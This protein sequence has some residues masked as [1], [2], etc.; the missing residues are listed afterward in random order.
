MNKLILPTKNYLSL[1]CLLFVILAASACSNENCIENDRDSK[2]MAEQKAVLEELNGFTTYY[3]NGVYQFYNSQSDY[4]NLDSLDLYILQYQFPTAIQTR[5]EP[6]ADTSIDYKSYFSERL[7]K[8]GYNLISSFIYRNDI[9]IE[10]FLE[11]Q[12]QVSLLGEADRKQLDFIMDATNIIYDNIRNNLANKN[13]TT[14]SRTGCNIATTVA[15]FAAGAIWGAAFGGPVGVAVSL[16]WSI[17]G[18]IAAQETC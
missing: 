10:D 4:V 11:L 8:E 17:A 1:A 9:S 14:R 7:S 6:Y 16:A 18:A 2:I 13:I 5:S 15:S 12:K 3:M